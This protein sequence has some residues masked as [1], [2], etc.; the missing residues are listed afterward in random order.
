MGRPGLERR[1]RQRG[2][3]DR[4]QPLREPARGRLPRRGHDPDD[5]AQQHLRE[6]T[7]GGHRR[8]PR[9]R[10]LLLRQRLPA[11]CAGGLAGRPR[12]HRRRRAGKDAAVSVISRVPVVETVSSAA[13]FEELAE[14]WDDLVRGMPR[15]SPF[16]LHAWLSEWWS[17]YGVSGALAVHVVRQDG[18]L[19]GA[20]PLIVSSKRGV[21]VVRFMGGRQSVLADLLLAPGADDSV[22]GLL[23]ARLAT[24]AHG[25]VNL[26]GIPIGS[27]I[28]DALGPDRF[29]VIVR[30]EAPVLDL[31]PDWTTVYEQK[32]SAKTRSLH[33]RRR[34][35]LAALG[36]L[37]VSVARTRAELEPALEEA[38]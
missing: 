15:A 9:D 12:A 34:R 4:G 23:A 17:H 26:Y 24:S 29:D 20:L 2:Q 30:I 33:R 14:E 3:R 36:R 21:R 7:L 11:D 19:V 27:R 32:T 18:R 16:L 10:E 31:L 1:A 22:A 38:F 37:E 5:G 35:Q 25:L 28:V 8:L 6:S 13:A